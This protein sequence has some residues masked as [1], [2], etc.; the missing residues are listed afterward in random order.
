MG[1]R[2]FQLLFACILLSYHLVWFWSVFF[3][4]SAP[5]VKGSREYFIVLALIELAVILLA[6]CYLWIYHAPQKSLMRQKR[7]QFLYLIGACMAWYLC[8]SFWA[9]FIPTTS[10]QVGLN[11]LI[12]TTG[13]KELPYLLLDMCLF[14][15]I[16]EELIYRGVVMTTFFKQSPR[17]LDVLLSTLLFAYVHVRSGLTPLAFLIYA[18]SGLILGLL[19]RKTQSLLYPIL[20]HILMNI[21]AFW[22]VI[23]FVLSKL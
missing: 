10:N 15:P 17:Y 19:Y 2:V 22:Y 6:S 9:L 3:Y 14:G 7:V 20:M 1:K 13:V 8:D 11:S 5:Y 18:S 21:L 4:F 12:E 16:L 23:L